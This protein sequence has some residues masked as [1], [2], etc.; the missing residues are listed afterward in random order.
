MEEISTG[1]GSYGKYV[2]YSWTTMMVI[3]LKG[4]IKLT[5]VAHPD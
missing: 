2:R 3:Y 4:F 5:L 1:T